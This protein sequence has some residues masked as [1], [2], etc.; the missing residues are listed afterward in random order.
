M[1]ANVSAHRRANAFAKALEALEALESKHQATR[2]ET[3]HQQPGSSAESAEQR[4]MVALASGLGELPAP[5]LD[6]EVRTTQRAQLIAAMEAAFAEGGPR[7]PEQRRRPGGAHRAKPPVSRLRPRSRWSKGLAAGGLTVGVA[8]G[9]FGGVA[10]AS[11]DALPGDTLYGF[12]RGMEDL[13][14]EMA[15]GDA[16]RGRI[17]LDQAS[18]RMSEARRLMERARSGELDHDSLREIRRALTGMRHD[19]SE[20][21]RLL[22]QVYE[23]DGSLGPM[24]ELSSFAKAHRD[25]WSQLRERLPF[26]LADV[27]DEVSSVFAAIDQEV[28]PL[29]PLLPTTKDQR[30]HSGRPGAEAPQRSGG[31]S[32]ERHPSSASAAPSGGR[33]DETSRPRPSAPVASEDQGLI[34]GTGDLLDP[35][36][37][38]V[39]PSPSPGRGDTGSKPTQPDITIPPLL[40]DLLPGL[41][42]NG[43]DTR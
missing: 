26:Q 23:R 12:K 29:Q 30:S 17:Y 34:G 14:L 41:D 16:A 42:L 8:A 18:T 32:P 19:A 43:D 33:T 9:A 20:G 11:S 15:D 10:A 37:G 22:H 35:P 28:G 25:S 31:V 13:K 6:P 24:Q 1:I 21:H 38:A 7:V 3:P 4:R 27:R 36:A 39:T 5:V 40:P 2:D